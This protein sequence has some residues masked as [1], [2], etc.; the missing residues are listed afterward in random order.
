MEKGSFS[1]GWPLTFV[2]SGNTPY[3]SLQAL[4]FH[5]GSLGRVLPS[6]KHRQS[7]S[8]IVHMDRVCPELVQT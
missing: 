8:R 6:M 7:L 2:P 5:G 1:D 3:Q 4:T